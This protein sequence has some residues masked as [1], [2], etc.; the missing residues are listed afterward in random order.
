[1]P[2]DEKN[3][4]LKMIGEIMLCIAIALQWDQPPQG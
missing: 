2:V 3:R 4:D 1:M